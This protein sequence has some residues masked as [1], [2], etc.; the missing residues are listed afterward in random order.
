MKKRYFIILLII[1]IILIAG[2]KG[3]DT[4]G[5][6]YTIRYYGNGSTSGFPPEDPRQYVSGETATVM[7]KN[8]LIKTGYDFLGWNEK[9]NGNGKK[10]DAGAP[11]TV[12][13]A[14]IHLYPIWV[15]LP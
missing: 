7:D 4:E 8:T 9:A 12:K 15:K 13:N 2:C 3:P 10:Y 14:N 6:T 1:S 5:K 11:I